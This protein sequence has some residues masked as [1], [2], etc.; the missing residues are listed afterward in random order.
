M[1]SPCVLLT[2]QNCI[3]FFVVSASQGSTN[4][5]SID[6]NNGFLGWVKGKILMFTENGKYLRTENY[7]LLIIVGIIVV[8]SDGCFSIGLFI[9]LLSGGFCFR[10]GF[11]PNFAL[12]S[13]H[14]RFIFTMIPNFRVLRQLLK[15]KSAI[16]YAGNMKYY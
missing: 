4:Q 11:S 9:I 6:E 3:T 16:K 13:S 12:I 8:M 7:C 5:M 10:P 14:V 2:S 15:Q 1:F